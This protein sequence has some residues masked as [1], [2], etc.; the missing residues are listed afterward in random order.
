M[1]MNTDLWQRQ[2]FFSS[3]S[4]K[5]CTGK[6]KIKLP[7]IWANKDIPRYIFKIFYVLH[8]FLCFECI[9]NRQSISIFV[10]FNRYR[11]YFGYIHFQRSRSYEIELWSFQ[12]EISCSK[13]H[14]N[15]S[16]NSAK[17]VV[18][19][20]TSRIAN[21]LHCPFCIWYLYKTIPPS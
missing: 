21:A 8:N 5:R 7:K 16:H 12:N 10:S 14:T 2:A 3:Y 9:S 15:G 4:L 20:L 17:H 18:P 1:V 11:L 19:I 6:S 13:R